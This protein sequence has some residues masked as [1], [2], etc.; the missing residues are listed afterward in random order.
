[1][2]RFK[3]ILILAIITLP[4]WAATG[5]PVSGGE[6][7]APEQWVVDPFAEW[8]EFQKLQSRWLE[9]Q[10]RYPDHEAW[11]VRQIFRDSHRKLFRTYQEGASLEGLVE[12]GQFD[13]VV[14]SW[15]LG[16]LFEAMGFKVTLREL[17]FHT[18]LRIEGQNVYVLEVTDPH[19]GVKEG[20]AVIADYEAWV[21]TQDLELWSGISTSPETA[22]FL[23]VA[24]VNN[25]LTLDQLP[26]LYAYNQA[27]RAWSEERHEDAWSWISL[28]TR[29]YSS[30]R[31]QGFS[32]LISSS[33]STQNTSGGRSEALGSP[34]KSPRK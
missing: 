28:S 10:S 22:F 16:S 9:K 33:L 26:G 12:D 24:P 15:A 11:L 27:I 31:T 14:G 30:T 1:M 18:Y 19:Q 3:A 25:L 2:L 29:H 23:R 21:H 8:V 34:W 7:R 13:C 6:E 5:I 4:G 20:E 17:N 32:K